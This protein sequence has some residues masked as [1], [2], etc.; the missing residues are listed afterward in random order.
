MSSAATHRPDIFAFD[1]KTCTR[2]A[3]FA[4]HVNHQCKLRPCACLPAPDAEPFVYG[5][6]QAEILIYSVAVACPK[7]EYVEGCIEKE[8]ELQEG[9]LSALMGRKEG[10]VERISLIDPVLALS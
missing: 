5:L 1:S 9:T 3:I 6:Q 8:R 7:F 10:D 4:P 2:S